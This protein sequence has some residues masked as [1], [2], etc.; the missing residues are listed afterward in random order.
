MST[1]QYARF[2][3]SRPSGNVWKGSTSDGVSRTLTAAALGAQTRKLAPD[4]SGKR[5]APSAVV[6]LVTDVTWYTTAPS[7][8]RCST[9]V[10]RS[11]ARSV[12]ACGM[13]TTPHD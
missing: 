11:P 1:D 5:L 2:A 7:W 4:L 3:R 9:G 8:V 6:P 12:S 13:V 10:A